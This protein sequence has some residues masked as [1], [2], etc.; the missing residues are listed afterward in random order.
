[1]SSGSLVFYQ[2]QIH[3]IPTVN[4][5]FWSFAI[6]GKV[7][8]PLILSLADLL[9]LPTQTFPCAIACANPGKDYPLMGEAI[10]RGVP[11]R[12][13]LDQVKI[14]P[15]VRYA[16]ISAADGYTTV[17]PIDRLTSTLLAYEMDGAPLPVEHGYPARLLAPGLHGYKMAKW[18]ERIELRDTAD[19]GFWESRGFSLDG[20]ASVKTAILD[21]TPSANGVTLNGIAYAG[22][23]RIESVQVSIDDGDWMPVS[24]RANDPTRLTRWQI[25]WTPP[26]AGAYSARVRASAASG[27]TE[28]SLVIRVD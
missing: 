18:L 19:G 24:F 27:S 22:L 8:R 2:Q 28:H 23:R 7:Q 25:E 21:T 17:L 1:M 16:R 15:G 12:A 3:D 6:T 9:A 4:P 10:W 14:D 13:L 20:E 26:G 5:N 11:L